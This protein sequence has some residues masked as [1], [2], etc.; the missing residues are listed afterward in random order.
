MI[1]SPVTLSTER[2]GVV[3]VQLCD[4]VG[5]NAL[6]PNVIDGLARAI[7]L[8]HADREVRVCLLRGLA[9]VFCAGGSAD[10]LLA[11][12]RGESAPVDIP[13]LRQVLEIPVP[14]IAALEGPAVGGGLMLGL[15][16][17]IVLLARESRYGCPFVDLGFTPGAGATRLLER[18]VGEYRAAEMLYGGEFVRGQE[19]EGKTDINYVLP[20]AQVWPK[21]LAI[22]ARIADKPR[23]VLELLKRQLALPKRLEFEAARTVEASLHEVCFARPHAAARIESEYLR[24]SEVPHHAE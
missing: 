18:A 17:D 13:L 24:A 2:D 5:R 21:A 12:A 15:C 10:M 16:C 20:R 19:L 1:A 8:V 9:E 4:R 11:L 23:H 22:A 14:T 6:G 7:E 3:V